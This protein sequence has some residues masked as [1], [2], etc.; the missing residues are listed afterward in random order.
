MPL[1]YQA[2]V[3][4][5]VQQRQAEI[6]KEA[7]EKKWC[8]ISPVTGARWHTKQYSTVARASA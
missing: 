8:A 7:L 3:G 2:A 1:S 4:G 6:V 5:F